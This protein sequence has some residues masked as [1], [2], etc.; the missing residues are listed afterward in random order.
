MLV[1]GALAVDIPQ[2][3]GKHAY[4]CA[5]SYDIQQGTEGL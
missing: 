2:L 1:D 5:V 3:K 4:I